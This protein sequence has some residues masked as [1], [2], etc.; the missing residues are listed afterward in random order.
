MTKV[1]PPF[2]PG[3]SAPSLRELLEARCKSEIKQAVAS[4]LA[5][6]TGVSEIADVVY[7]AVEVEPITI[8]KKF[9]TGKVRTRTFTAGVDYRLGTHDIMHGTRHGD[10]VPFH[11]QIYVLEVLSGSEFLA[12][13][14]SGGAYLDSTFVSLVGG[15]I[16]LKAYDDG[17]R[18]KQIGD[19]EGH[20]LKANKTIEKWNTDELPSAIEKEVARQI[21]AQDSAERRRQKLADDGFIQSDAPRPQIVPLPNKKKQ[22]SRASEPNKVQVSE[23][24]GWALNDNQFVDIL[25]AIETHQNNVERLP[26]VGADPE[27]DEEGHRDSLLAALNMRF[28]DG[29]AE[30][31]SNQGKT[32]I[33]LVHSGHSYFYAECKI[34]KGPRSVDDAFTQLV[35][36][37]LIHRDRHGA[38]IFFVRGNKNPELLPAKAI[39]KMEENHN[40]RRVDDI[41]GFPVLQ[42]PHPTNGRQIKLALVF[43][44]V[45]SST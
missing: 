24:V 21:Q 34:W 33:R 2:T 31:F 27:A 4:E 38:L 1:F 44:T 5:T 39:Q 12:S 15:N 30:S 35:E 10:S 16:E 45:D 7:K 18:D 29:T 36:R 25:E 19:I 3:R 23:G 14:A 17:H 41:G 11:D 13:Q 22:I 40:S 20:V 6:G 42:S 8:G 37:Y 9:A 28:Q 26:G 43:I 32:D